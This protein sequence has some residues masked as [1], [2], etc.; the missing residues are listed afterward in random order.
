MVHQQATKYFNDHELLFKAQFRFR[1]GYSTNTYILHLLDNIYNN[2]DA[3]LITGAV[4]LDLNKAFDKFEHIIEKI[5]VYMVILIF[6]NYS[7]GRSQITKCN[8]VILDLHDVKYCVP[9][10]AILGPLLFIIYAN[11]LYEYIQE[12]NIN[13][14]ADNTIVYHASNSY[15]QLILKIKV[16]EPQR[17]P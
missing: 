5:M 10:G 14:H 9:Q 12:C 7:T 4:F 11:D 15:I 2:I 1:K 13:L 17:Y 6:K 3:G 16:V 8:Y